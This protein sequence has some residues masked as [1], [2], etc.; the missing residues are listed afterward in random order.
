MSSICQA[1]SG[2]WVADGIDLCSLQCAGG[3][4]DFDRVKQAGFSFVYIKCTQ[5]SGI[6]DHAFPRLRDAAKKAGLHVGAYHFCS[7]SGMTE[8]GGYVMTDPEAQM[9]FFHN[10]SE[11]LGSLP[12]ELPPMIDWEFCTK[13]TKHQCVTWLH[14]AASAA[15]ALWYPQNNHVEMLEAGWKPRFP[16]IYTYP[17]YAATHQ[18]E[19]GEE[20][21]LKQYP[22]CYASY[23][24]AGQKL[25]PWYPQAG[26]APL[27]KVPKPWERALLVQYSGNNGIKVAGIQADCDRQVFTGTKE[28]W[29]AFIGY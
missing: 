3:D 5:Y 13:P 18:P 19:L 1:G 22:L 2:V 25:L 21:G 17:N 9:E 23:K 11:G 26:E 27:H 6:R 8:N 15:E 29:D 7:Q 16:V 10:T 4:P 20:D 12:G 14:K 24:S 28:E